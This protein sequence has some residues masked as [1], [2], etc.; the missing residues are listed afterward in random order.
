MNKIYVAL[1]FSCQAIAIFSRLG[2]D[3]AYVFNLIT[4]ITLDF[5]D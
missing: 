2:I 4:F 5:I 1:G 3:L